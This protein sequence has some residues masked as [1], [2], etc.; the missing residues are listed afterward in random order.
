MTRP[1]SRWPTFES[2]VKITP[3]CWLW[4]GATDGKGYGSFQP[5]GTRTR[6]KAHRFAYEVLVGPIPDELELDHVRSRGCTNTKC[7][8][9]AHLEPVTHAENMRRSLHL[10][11]P[12]RPGP[13]VAFQRTKTRCPQNHPYD[14][15]NTGVRSNGHRYCR[16]CARERMAR[17]R[18]RNAA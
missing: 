14:S 12:G 11:T 5:P 7:V 17:N 3:T 10:P 18:G 1:F 9:P 16:E 15:A 8:N 2:K 4:T 6:V 13:A